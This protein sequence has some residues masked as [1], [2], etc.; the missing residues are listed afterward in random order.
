M[1]L[2]TALLSGFIFGAGLAVSGMT[3]TANVLGF[4][5]LF[6]NWD[7]SLAFV[8]G[9]ALLLT[10]TGFYVILK[11]ERPL[12]DSQFYL[13]D[14]T[15]IDKKLIVGAIFFG[16]GWGL[17]GYCPGP[18]VASIAYLEPETAIFLVS[19]ILGMAAARR[20]QNR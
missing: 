12:L 2:I 10:I 16:I 6:G 7:P 14:T 20:A 4:L 19:M 13:P 18:A 15:K 11:K 9:G 5:D 17:Y 8:M 3:D 1:N